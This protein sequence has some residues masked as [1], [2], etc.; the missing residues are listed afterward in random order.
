MGVN[1]SDDLVKTIEEICDGSSCDE[2]SQRVDNVTEKKDQ[3]FFL[4]QSSLSNG[5]LTRGM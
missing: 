1:S 2:T 5:L 4:K 3:R